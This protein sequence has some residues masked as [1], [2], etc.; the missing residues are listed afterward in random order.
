MTF[1]CQQPSKV[2]LLSV[3]FNSV[4]GCWR[5]PPPAEKLPAA[6]G[7]CTLRPGAVVAA[8]PRPPAQS[9]RVPRCRRR[10]DARPAE[11]LDAPLKCSFASAAIL[12]DASRLRA[13]RGGCDQGLDLPLLREPGSAVQAD[14]ARIAVVLTHPA[15][16]AGPRGYQGRVARRTA[17]ILRL[18][19][20]TP[21]RRSDHGM[22]KRL[23]GR[24]GF[25][26]DLARF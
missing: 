14:G 25:S 3:P 18:A 11:L 1:R 16:R 13:R 2:G 17:R 6:V 20:G 8:G 5:I 24:S 9:G 4:I 26:P 23:W 19:G 15:V 7:S 21:R 10:N 12:A 22:A